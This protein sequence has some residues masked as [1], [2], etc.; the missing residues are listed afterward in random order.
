[1]GHTSRSKTGSW[2]QPTLNAEARG[3]RVLFL[4]RPYRSH[5]SNCT[6]SSVE[7]SRYLTIT[8]V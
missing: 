7:A 4:G 1:M 3:V 2:Y 8:G 5:S 6:R